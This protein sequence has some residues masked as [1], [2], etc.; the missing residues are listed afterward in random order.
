MSDLNP[1][2]V[3]EKSRS[4]LASGDIKI[5]KETYR[6]FSFWLVYLSSIVFIVIS[7]AF[8]VIGISELIKDGST[9]IHNF[10]LPIALIVIACIITYF[11]PFYSSITVDL[12]NKIVI[13][14]KYKLFF[15]VKKIVR[16]ET[17]NIAKV[18]TEKNLSEGYGNDDKNSVDGF[19]LV[20]EMNNGEKII[21]LEGEIDKNYEMTKVGYFMSKFFPGLTEEKGENQQIVPST[22]ENQ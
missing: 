17:P 11:F 1:L 14:K 12:S 10:L 21:G 19:N 16:I 20:F 6:I 7:M 13:C 3:G 5:P 22:E 18:Y 4:F 8:L 9:S 2:E 15:F